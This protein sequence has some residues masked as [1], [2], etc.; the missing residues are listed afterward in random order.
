MDNRS[1]Y[2]IFRFIFIAFLVLLGINSPEARDEST[3]F[4]SLRTGATITF[5]EGM[6]S[7]VDGENR[8]ARSLLLGDVYGP[9]NRL[10]TGVKGRMSL[11][12]PNGGHIRLDQ[13]TTVELLSMDTDEK[14]GEWKTKIDLLSGNLWLS[15][16]E[17]H[18]RKGNLMVLTPLASVE[19]ERGVFR[20]AVNGASKSL[21]V[22]VYQGNVNIQKSEKS[23]PQNTSEPPSK[24]KK[25]WSHTVKPMYQIYVRPNGSA[26][27]PFRFTE[28]ADQN[29]WVLWN[30]SQDERTENP[31]HQ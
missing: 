29:N 21:I 7:L 24:L 3:P 14:T 10:R 28:K 1:P 23:V 4:T 27:F 26:T 17:I 13:Q 12:L 9:G 15:L 30:L 19:M 25:S 31:P 5:L 2:F 18:K 11:K 16:P 20:L 6:A 22:K 8:I